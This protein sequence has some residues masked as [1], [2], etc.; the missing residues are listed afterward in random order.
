[1]AIARGLISPALNRACRT[2]APERLPLR[3]AVPVLLGLSMLSWMIVW[4]F[5]RLVL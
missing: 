4:A 1:M 3:L 5:L 2:E